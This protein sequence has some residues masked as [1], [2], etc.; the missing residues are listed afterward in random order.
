MAGSKEEIGRIE[1]LIDESGIIN[2]N[3]VG[4]VADNKTKTNGFYLGN[5]SQ[6]DEIIK[7]HKVDEI[8]FCARDISSQKII[9]NMLKF[10]HLNVDYKIAT[11]DGI[12][13]IGSNSINTAGDLYSLQINTIVTTQN[14]RKKRIVDVCFS[15]IILAL[16]PVFMI[17]ST[18]I[19]GILRN[20]V[21]VLLGVRSWV[22]YADSDNNDDHRIPRIKQGIVSTITPYRKQNLAP[23]KIARLNLVYSKDY[24]MSYD[25]SILLKSL[26]CLGKYN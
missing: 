1:K 12:S 5:M 15:V 8:I 6:L 3:I 23:K 4:Y 26:P 7:V 17:I 2:P 14:K 19:W 10:S 20:T 25:L 9:S 13:V 24:R 18:S 16:L 22:G 11:P 21:L